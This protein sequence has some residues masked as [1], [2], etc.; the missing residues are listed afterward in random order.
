MAGNQAEG[1]RPAADR[2]LG[3]RFVD[4]SATLTQS[5]DLAHIKR[6]DQPLERRPPVRRRPGFRRAD[7]R[8]NPAASRASVSIP[9]QSSAFT[10][11]FGATQDPPTQATFDRLK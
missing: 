5:N 2:P 3:R 8:A 4:V 11:S 7:Q 1:A 9:A 6:I 10:N